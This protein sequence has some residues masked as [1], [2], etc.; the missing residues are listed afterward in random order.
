MR[1]DCLKQA[2]RPNLA[3]KA[4][5]KEGTFARCLEPRDVGRRFE[6]D[7]A[8]P[9][10][11][12]WRLN[13]RAI[14]WK[15]S[16][17][18]TSDG[19]SVNCLDCSCTPACA[20]ALHPQADGFA[21]VVIINIAELSKAIGIPVVARYDPDP[22]GFENPCHYLLQPRGKSIDDMAQE[23]RTWAEEIFKSNRKVPKT[24]ADQ[25]KAIE[26]KAAYERVLSIRP[27]VYPPQS[28][29][30]SNGAPSSSQVGDS[31]PPPAG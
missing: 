3:P 13:L 17:E 30:E 9:P 31:S 1:A 19:V 4:I 16:N 10:D 26:Q 22:D 25:Q 14:D 21:H 28:K 6:R 5:V 15:A 23:L 20:V 8:D 29:S 11:F 24:P 18:Q 7:G 27:N 12:G 2:V